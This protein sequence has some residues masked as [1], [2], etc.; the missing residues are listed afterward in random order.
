MASY[1]R[2]LVQVQRGPM[3]TTTIAIRP[4][5][6]PL[7]EELHGEGA[8]QVV[9]EEEANVHAERLGLLNVEPFDISNDLEL[10]YDRL[11]TFYGMHPEVK[12]PIVER[13]YG[14]FSEGRF[15]KAVR[16]A[17]SASRGAIDDAKVEAPRSAKALSL[18]ELRDQADDLGIE[19]TPAMTEGEIKAEIDKLIKEAA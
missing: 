2:V 8:V 1:K 17:C 9:T 5:E 19:W 10:E 15:S 11:Q 4:W 14:K 3:S 16:Q 18:D 7:L 13:C 12:V 6:R